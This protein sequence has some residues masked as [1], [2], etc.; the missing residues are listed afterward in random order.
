MGCRRQRDGAASEAGV[1]RIHGAHEPVAS[2]PVEA[3]EEGAWRPVHGHEIDRHDPGLGVAVA[4]PPQLP[5][6]RLGRLDQDRG[7]V[8]GLHQLHGRRDAPLRLIGVMRGGVVDIHRRG[9]AGSRTRG[10]HHLLGP[11][12]TTQRLAL[13]MGSVTAVRAGTCLPKGLWLQP[14]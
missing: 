1:G 10:F 8:G 7:V 4:V 2:L 11:I 12:R 3:A 13:G 6:P 5:R 9:G 14:G